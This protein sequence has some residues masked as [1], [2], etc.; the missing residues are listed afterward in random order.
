MNTITDIKREHPDYVA[1]KPQFRRFRDLYVGGEEI[2]QHARDYL[3]TRQKEPADI[4]QERL[5]RVFYENYIGSI[6]DWYSATLFRREPVLGFDGSEESKRFFNGFAED[7]DLKGTSL[8]AMLRQQ[9]TAALVDGRS[10]LLVDFPR[11]TAAVTTRAEEE[12]LGVS[13]AYVVDYNARELINWSTDEFGAYE[14]IVL[15]TAHQRPPT[16]GQPEWTTETRWQ[17]YDRRTYQVWTQSSAT[18]DARPVL[19]SE[20]LHAMSARERVP[21]FELRVSEGLW[22]MNK[23]SQLQLEHFNKS[24]ALSWALTMGLFAMPVIYSD[25]DWKQVVGESYYIQLGQQD[26]FGWTEPEGRVFQIA[27]ENLG[28]LQEEIYRVCYLLHQAR[29]LQSSGISQSGLSKQRDFAITQEVLRAFGDTVK[30]YA[31]RVLRAISVAREDA[32][33][34]DVGGMDDF[35]IGE[36]SSDLADAER[37]LAMGIASPTLRSTIFKK[38][39]SKYLSDVRQEVKDRISDEIESSLGISRS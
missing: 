11:P 35:D 12:D 39:A 2:R 26:R 18:K 23:A 1:Q 15:R 34:I 14:W 27:A 6:I 7:C 4:Y 3:E 38:L 22:L 30:D 8:T 19:I 36:F 17:Y 13:R 25:R 9:F 16:A 20:G 29:G 5:G 33:V 31:K 32:I 10:Y 37:L 21:L 24:N 28:R